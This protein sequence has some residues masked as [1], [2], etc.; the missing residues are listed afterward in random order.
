MTP[1]QT[2]ELV[3]R[4]CIGDV[5]ESDIAVRF[6]AQFQ[7]DGERSEFVDFI[8]DIPNFLDSVTI[9]ADDTDEIYDTGNLPAVGETFRVDIKKVSFENELRLLFSGSLSENSLTISEFRAIKI[10]DFEKQNEFKTVYTDFLIWEDN[11]E[12]IAQDVGILPDPRKFAVDFVRPPEVPKDIRPWLVTEWPADIGGIPTTWSV[13]ASR[14]LMASIS[15]R[16][17]KADDAIIYHFD[18]PPACSFS[19]ADHEILTKLR[20]LVAGADFVFLNAPGDADAR[21]LLLANE[22]ARSYR[23]SSLV[24]L[25]ENCVKSAATAYSAYIK[26]KSS[27]MLSE[28]SALRKSV[29]EETKQIRDKG[30]EFARAMWKDLAVAAA[31]FVVKVLSDAA[32]TDN[33]EIAKYLSFAAAA[34]LTLSLIFQ[35]FLS[36]RW[37]RSQVKARGIWR[38]E[39]N[40]ALTKDEMR[41][42]ADDPISRSV[43]DYRAVGALVTGFYAVIIYVLIQYG[44]GTLSL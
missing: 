1:K 10:A 32:Q 28:L 7:E 2:A 30:H 34:F 18:G 38:L 31:P 29:L 19:L 41:K 17:S 27:E 39:I 24:D 11:T 42:I 9:Y 21:H 20:R 43:L 3:N 5:R 15:D 12:F 6:G 26:A 35:W 37:L 16:V 13:L 33:S 40:T 22:W 23:K 8:Q 36:E 4:I 44:R 14:N 25:G